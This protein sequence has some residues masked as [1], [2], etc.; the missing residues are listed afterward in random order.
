[1]VFLSPS[2]LWHWSQ[3]F[4][5]GVALNKGWAGWP[6]Q[7]PPPH[8]LTQS[9]HFRG[10]LDAKTGHICRVKIRHVPFKTY[11][12]KACFAWKTERQIAVSPSEEFLQSQSA[13]SHILQKPQAFRSCWGQISY[14][15][16]MHWLLHAMKSVVPVLCPRKQQFLPHYTQRM[17]A[18]KVVCIWFMNRQEIYDG[19]ARLSNLWYIKS[20]RPVRLCKSGG[21]SA[22]PLLWTRLLK[23]SDGYW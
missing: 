4:R 5:T 10:L 8:W 6:F 2:L 12:S 7:R 9:P 17:C 20:E 3:K 11:S 21:Q 19:F 23:I 14:V 1:M 16:S 18:D 15:G 22:K 13:E